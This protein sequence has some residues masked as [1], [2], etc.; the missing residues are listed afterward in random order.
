MVVK[1]V[2][3]TTIPTGQLVAITLASRNLHRLQFYD[4]FFQ[5]RQRIRR[6]DWRQD[7]FCN[8]A[9]LLNL[10]AFATTR[11]GSVLHRRNGLLRTSP[12]PER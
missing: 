2:L 1:V 3:T 9:I 8:L 6:D 12:A 11:R 7:D 4:L 10:V 5:L